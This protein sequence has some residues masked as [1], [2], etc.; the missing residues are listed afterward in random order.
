MNKKWITASLLFLSMTAMAQKEEKETDKKDKE[1]KEVRSR[2]LSIMIDG[3]RVMVNGK[4][5]KDMSPEELK[6]FEDSNTMIFPKGS[7]WAWGGKLPGNADKSG[8]WAPAEMAP[9]A[10]LGVLSEPNDKGAKITSI[11][12]ESAA[13]K[14]GLQ[15]DDIITKV[16]DQL[17]KNTEDLFDAIGEHK[18]N[19][20]VTITYLRD[21]KE[22]TVSATL[23]ETKEGFSFNT[24]MLKGLKGLEG[25]EGLKGLE[26]WQG[27]KGLQ[28]L[29]GLKGLERL[30]EFPGFR[31]MIA[32]KPRLGLQI[33][34]METGKG[35]KVLEVYDD[36]PADKAGLKK[37]DIIEGVNGKSIKN[38]DELQTAMRAIQEGETV[39]AS[40][41]RSGKSLQVDIKFPKKLKTADL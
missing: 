24:E 29:E 28:G 26:G 23:G 4:N 25:L 27:L 39:K 11:T 19:E 32:P 8:F 6:A 5:I 20:K 41:N 16:N 2:K 7:V 30:E 40:I 17:I 9:R 14:A 36:S 3:D 18:P 12:K 15:K 38:V 21:G 31:D 34:D 13:E 10:F 22:N 35:V 37:D 1:I 33:Q